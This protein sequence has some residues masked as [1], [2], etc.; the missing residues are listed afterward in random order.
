MCSFTLVV[1]FTIFGHL[2]NRFYG[3]RQTYV[4]GCHNPPSNPSVP[5]ASLNFLI[6][7]TTYIRH[8][9]NLPQTQRETSSK[10]G[11]QYP[12]PIK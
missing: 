7:L 8:H 1:F 3:A 11:V 4:W 6:I 5:T 12:L 9:Q 10:R 2:R